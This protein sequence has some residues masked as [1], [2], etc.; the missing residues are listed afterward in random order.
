[1]SE[2]QILK[3]ENLVKWFPV[4]KSLLDMLL[5][6]QLFIRAVDGINFEIKKGEFFGLVGESG[7][8]KTTTA[9]LILRVIQPTSGKVYFLGK[10]IFSIKN[11][12]ELLKFRREAHMIF[13]DPYESLSPR[14]SIYQILS[15]PLIIHKV[16]KDK[17]ERDKLIMQI[18]EDV[19]LPSTKEFLRKR[20]PMLS[21]GQRQ[22]VSIARHLVLRPRFVVA[23]EPVSMLDA[24]LRGSILN[25]MTSLKEK[26]E[27]TYL[28][29][30]HDIS[31]AWHVC[32][33]IGVM[34]LGKIVE[35]GPSEAIIKYPK[36]PYAQALMSAVPKGD[37]STKS[38]MHIDQK[39]HGQVPKLTSPPS[40][41]RFHSRCPYAKEKCKMKEPELIKVGK[42]HYVA[43][44]YI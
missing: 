4:S 30:T 19:G 34:Y 9:R 35:I 18:L 16:C 7:C 39:I 24:S 38:Y 6:K 31:L 27:I 22:R 13:Q 12:K 1:M 14:L 20:P 41:C 26:L 3:V 25:L 36:H 28:L 23:D 8:G 40:G 29:I 2:N 32:E 43:C 44:H 42:D 33:R 5:R 10:D 17:T 37:P 11:R 21:G 15:E